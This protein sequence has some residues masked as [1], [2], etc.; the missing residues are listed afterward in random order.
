[1]PEWYVTAVADRRNPAACIAFAKDFLDA[2]PAE[3]AEVVKSWDPELKWELPSPQRLACIDETPGSPVERIRADLLFQ[4]LG[5]SGAD[6]R[7]AIMGFAVIH[8]SCKLAGID[9]ETIFEEIAD[10]VGGAGATALRDF[11]NRDP[12][13]KSM[14]AFMLEAVPSSGGGYEVHAKW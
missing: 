3:R 2:P 10:A 11:A 5:L 1:M 7:E 13:D 8:N 12:E 9:P 14:E 4:V 6:A